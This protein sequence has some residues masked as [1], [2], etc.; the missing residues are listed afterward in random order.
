MTRRLTL[1]L[2]IVSVLAVL[3]CGERSTDAPGAPHREQID[4]EREAQVAAVRLEPRSR[5]LEVGATAPDFA[6]LPA[7]GPAIVVFYRGHW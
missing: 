3:A 7:R 2:A 5:P 4:A 1:G 6:A